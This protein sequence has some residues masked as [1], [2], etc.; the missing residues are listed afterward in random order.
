MRTS[1]RIFSSLLAILVSFASISPSFAASAP[2]D[3][4]NLF[5]KIQGEARGKVGFFGLHWN[6]ENQSLSVYGYRGE[7]LSISTRDKFFG[8]KTAAELTAPGGATI[9]HRVRAGFITL[10]TI[11]LN[12]ALTDVRREGSS[13]SE[14]TFKVS[15]EGQGS[16]V[17]HLTQNPDGSMRASFQ[18]QATERLFFKNGVTSANPIP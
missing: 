1:T 15:A 3:P 17:I 7:T 5:L 13:I 11:R 18:N 8:T 2:A 10:A 14:A 12:V 16:A 6:G 4:G 9:T